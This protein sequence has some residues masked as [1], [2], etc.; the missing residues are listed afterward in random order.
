MKRINEELL[1]DILKNSNFFSKE[2]LESLM[3]ALI[4]VEESFIKIY[5]VLIPNLLKLKNVDKE[6]LQECLW[7]IREEFRHIYYHIH[8][9]KITD[10]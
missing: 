5:D 8:D 9:S 6:L 3:H 7:D 4:D 1:F 2:D 10:L